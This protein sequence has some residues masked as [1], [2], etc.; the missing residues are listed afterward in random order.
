MSK[1]LMTCPVFNFQD[2][3]IRKNHE[4]IRQMSEHEV[5]YIEV[6]GASVEHAKQIMY[7][8]FLEGD[9]DYLF[10]VDADIFFF[11]ED[12]SPIDIL[13][14]DNKD[15]VGGIYVYK[16]KPCLPTHRT[17][18]LQEYY[19]KNG[20]FP[21]DYKFTIPKELHE[22]RWLSGGCMM[23]K[24][25]VI[26]KL[27][28]KYIVPNL[29]MIYRREYLSEDFSFCQRAREEGY[30]IFAEPKLRLGHS[31]NYLYTLQDI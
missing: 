7:K 31:G 24:K 5:D 29:P 16:K 2:T 30:S 13:I 26:K 18:E 3:K 1:V 4:Q 15:I 9:Y 19:E 27:T 11:Y 17:L 25:D 8:K 28:E 23:I 20:E 22:V 6:I 14:E 21:K 10:N 12:K